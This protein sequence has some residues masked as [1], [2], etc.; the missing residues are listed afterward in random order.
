MLLQAFAA[1]GL[2]LL[3]A[4]LPAYFV[5]LS[6]MATSTALLIHT[7]N[8]AALSGSMVLGGCLA[9]EWAPAPVLL[10]TCATA[11][12]FAYLAWLLFSM[13][14]AEV[15][16]LAQC[17]LCVLLGLHWGALT[18]VLLD[19]FPPGV[20]STRDRPAIRPTS[21]QWPGL[22]LCTVAE[23]DASEI[24]LDTC[25]RPR[26]SCSHHQPL[27]VLSHCLVCQ[28]TCVPAAAMPSLLPYAA[29]EL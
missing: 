26:S 18:E 25:L 2:F 22:H 9:D 13:G 4:W 19:M 16:W 7:I 21:F 12:A 29:A 23:Q 1:S 14:V 5:A 17:I 27:R 24:G 15:T 28:L 10:A 20:S 8:M 6:G 3:A 11:I